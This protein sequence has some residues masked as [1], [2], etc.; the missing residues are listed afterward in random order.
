MCVLDD[1]DHVYISLLQRQQ[2]YTGLELEVV[3]KVIY[4]GCV[5]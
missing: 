4:T 2:T 5:Q 3:E 1:C